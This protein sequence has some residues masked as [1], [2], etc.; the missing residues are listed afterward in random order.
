MNEMPW[1]GFNVADS[2]VSELADLL[3]ICGV[4][5]WPDHLGRAVTALVRAEVDRLLVGDERDPGQ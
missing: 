5:S 4:P 3:S 1:A 2:W